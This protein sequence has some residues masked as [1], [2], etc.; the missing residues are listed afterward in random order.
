MTDRQHHALTFSNTFE[1]F[2][3]SSTVRYRSEQQ[4]N[5]A[6]GFDRERMVGF[7]DFCRWYRQQGRPFVTGWFDSDAIS[8]QRFFQQTTSGTSSMLTIRQRAGNNYQF[9]QVFSYQK[10]EILVYRTNP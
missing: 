8:L 7:K 9:R 10:P 2:A 5:A 4:L 3:F 1:A 6:I